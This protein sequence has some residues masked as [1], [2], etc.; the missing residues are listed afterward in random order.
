[1]NHLRFSISRVPR[2]YLYSTKSLI[3]IFSSK[4]A[5][6]LRNRVVEAGDQDASISIIP[7]L[8]QW[9]RE[10]NQV[11]PDNFQWL[12]RHLLQNGR[13]KHVLEISEWVAGGL[14]HTILPGDAPI[15]LKLIS[16]VY[17]QEQAENY[18]YSIPESM[19]S[20]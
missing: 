11:V 12:V 6:S 5:V 19:R 18:F 3:S 16:K 4:P 13:S 8:H 7:V 14:N 20:L 2:G 1:M 15:R 9:R 10:G 17:G